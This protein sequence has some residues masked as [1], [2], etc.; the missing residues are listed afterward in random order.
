MF[1]TRCARRE[2]AVKTSLTL[3]E[4]RVDALGTLCSRYNWQIY[5]FRRI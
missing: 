2:R 4:R 1:T 5:Y 3:C